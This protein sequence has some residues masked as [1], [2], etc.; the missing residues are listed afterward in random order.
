M[1]GAGLLTF[2]GLFM[3]P[4]V[5]TDSPGHFTSG[6]LSE[7]TGRGPSGGQTVTD[8]PPSDKHR[9]EAADR[10]ADMMNGA[11]S[12]RGRAVL[13]IERLGN[14]QGFC[15]GRAVDV[16]RPEMHLKCAEGFPGVFIQNAAEWYTVITVTP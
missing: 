15:I 14:G 4:H 9:R 12:L 7:F 16:F 5:L 1:T 10:P 8:V 2:S 11:S 3:R 6:L 13:L